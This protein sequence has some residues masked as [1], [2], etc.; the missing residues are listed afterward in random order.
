M[1][2]KTNQWV[3]ENI[4]LEWQE[5]SWITQVVWACDERGMTNCGDW[6][7]NCEEKARKTNINMVG[8]SGVRSP[9]QASVFRHRRQLLKTPT[10]EYIGVL[11]QTH[12][13]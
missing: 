6:R 10:C 5:A 13:F 2:R 12:A 1:E 11:W 7:N 9:L 4:K 8:H 3:L